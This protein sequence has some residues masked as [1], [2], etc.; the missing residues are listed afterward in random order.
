MQTSLLT[1]KVFTGVDYLRLTSPQAPTYD[2][3]LRLLEPEMRAERDAGRRSHQRGILG[4]YGP[5]GEHFF[6]GLGEQGAMLQLSGVAAHTYWREASRYSMKATRLDVQVTWPVDDEPGLYVREMYQIGQLQRPKNGHPPALEIN[7]TPSGA[8]MLTSGRRPSELY[9]RMY[10][11]YRESKQEDYK[12]CVRWEVEIKGDQAIDLLRDLREAQDAFMMTRTLVH[13]FWTA[14][15]MQPFWEVYEGMSEHPPVKRT[16]TDETKLAWFINQVRPTVLSLKEHGRVKD[17]IRALLDDVL[18]PEQV[19][20]IL[21]LIE[22]E[23][24]D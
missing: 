15:G 14:R 24:G 5:V 12:G 22:Q 2:H 11:K 1:K 4:Y 13:Q 21:L 7:D 9:G 8:K 19:D 10:D 23:R 6:C 3:W 17:A 16:K 20:G 18:T